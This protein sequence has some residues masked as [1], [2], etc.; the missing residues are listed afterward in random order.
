M[1]PRVAIPPYSTVSLFGTPSVPMKTARM[2]TSPAPV[3]RPSSGVSI[4]SISP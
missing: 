2:R 1:C 4:A 3:L